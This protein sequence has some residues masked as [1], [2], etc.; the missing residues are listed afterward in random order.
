M[1]FIKSAPNRWRCKAQAVKKGV[2][3]ES[4]PVVGLSYDTK[5]TAEGDYLHAE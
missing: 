5:P 3:I 2:E 4:P 1:A